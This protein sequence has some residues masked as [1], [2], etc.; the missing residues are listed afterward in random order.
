MQKDE[1]LE[2]LKKAI[3]A[4]LTGYQF[5]KNAAQNV[6]DPQAKKTLEAMAR[7]EMGHFNYLRKQYSSILEKGDYDFKEALEK[8][9]TPKQSSPI[10]SDEIRSRI[11][12]VH[13]EVSVLSIGM[14]LEQDA[15]AFYKEMAQKA[16][17]E[18][19]RAF[20]EQLAR[21]EQGH[22]EAF[23]RELEALKDDYWAA[24]SFVPM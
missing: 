24:N 7:E 9:E 13:F 5:Y 21:W 15:V 8:E 22:Y 3:E 20:Y 2:G 1:I 14:K 18:E 19:A 12:D 17:S 10:F 11:K 23:A 4:E 6:S 16:K